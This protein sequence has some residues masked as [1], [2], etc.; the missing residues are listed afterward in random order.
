MRKLSGT[1]AINLAIKTLMD[2]DEKVLT[3]GLGVNDPGK[4][5]GTTD[6]L[7]EI[8]GKHRVFETPTSELAMTG[9]GVGLALG[10][11]K[12]IHSHQRLDFALLAIDQLVNSAAKWRFMF[13][14]DFKIPYLVRMILGRGWGQGPTHSQNFESWFAHVPGIRVLVPATPQDFFDAV[15]S[16]GSTMDPV[17][18]VEHR[19]LHGV[20]SEVDSSQRPSGFLSPVIYKCQGH[21]QATLVT[22]GLATYDSLAAQATLMD[23]GINLE[24]I[25]IRELSEESFV[26]VA[27]SVKKTGKLAVAAN[28]W[29][30]ASF[31]DS[32]ISYAARTLNLADSASVSR[33][34]YPFHPEP[35]S[36]SQLDG[37]H[38]N[39]QRIVNEIFQMMKL[40]TRLTEPP[41]IDQP[42][43]FNFG[44]F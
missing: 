38:V 11:Y 22:W 4:V 21:A 35:T 18:L 7:L 12:S 36:V 8:F 15:L 23:W 31:A 32:V 24:V 17:V 27:D 33:I 9:V 44:P 20:T 26:A 34:A 42:K 41:A 37:Y 1:E 10:G 19:W 29:G 40:E 16:L 5:F 43:G 6:G 14:D 2:E 30:P 13:G 28:S 39:E 3:F 25:Q